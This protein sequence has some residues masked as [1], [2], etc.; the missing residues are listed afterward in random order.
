MTEVSLEDDVEKSIADFH[1]LI[2]L[3]F[4]EFRKN[5]W[6]TYCKQSPSPLSDTQ[7]TTLTF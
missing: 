6:I 4:K 7:T 5:A 2:C 1:T 3:H